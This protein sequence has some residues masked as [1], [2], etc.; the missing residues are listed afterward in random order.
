MKNRRRDVDALLERSR[1][2]LGLIEGEYQSSLNAKSIGS[3]L[4]IEIKNLCENLRSILDYLAHHIRETCCGAHRQHDRFYFPILPDRMVFA[5]RMAQWFPNLESHFPE[6]YGYLES[7]PAVPFG[8]CLAG[9]F[10][11]AE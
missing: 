10:Q 3:E 5:Q 4:K 7:C 11:S 1:A 9:P 8:I 6:L 2:N